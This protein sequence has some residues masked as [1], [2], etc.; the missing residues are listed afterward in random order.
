MEFNL[1]DSNLQIQ[2]LARDFAQNKIVPVCMKYDESQEFPMEIVKEIGDMGFMGIIF[3]GEFGGSGLTVLDY[4]IIIEEISKADPSIGLTVAAHNGLCTN[5]IFMFANEEQKKKYLPDLISGK[6]VGAWALTENVSGSDAAGMRSTAEKKNGYYILNGSKA[7]I[8][9]G[10]VGET[11]VVMAVTDKSKGHAI[12][13]SLSSKIAK[14]RQITL[15]DRKEK[16]LHR[17]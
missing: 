7:F 10:G 13:V 5:H 4:V 14:Y 16:V 11:A 2:K 17:Q 6:Q 1:T 15:L 3:P 12:H 9:H 8:T